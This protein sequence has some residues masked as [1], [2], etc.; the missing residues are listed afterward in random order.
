[1]I[2]RLKNRLQR[3]EPAAI[4]FLAIPAL[5]YIPVLYYSLDSVYTPFAVIDDSLEWVRLRIFDMFY[6]WLSAEFL[7]YD[8]DDLRY[9]PFWEFYTAVTWK[10]FGP[11]PWLHHLTRWATH[12]G[13]VA[14]FAAAFLCFQRRNRD[15]DVDSAPSR[16]VIRLLPLTALVYLWLFFPNQPAARLSAP[17][18][19]TVLFIALC[20]WMIALTLLRQGKPQT[21]RSTLLIYAVF[22]LSFCGIAWSKETNVA[23]ALWL[24]ISYY[25]LIAIEAMRRQRGAA[26]AS[27][28]S[29][30]K[31][32]SVW[33]A[34]GGLPLIAVFLHTLVKVYVI[35]QEGGYGTAPLTPDLLIGNAAWIAD[36]L[37]QANTSLII[38]VGF[39]LLSAALLLSTAVNIAKR[40]FSAELIFTLFLLG[41]FASLYLIVCT[42]WAQALRYWYILIPVFTTLLAFSIKR[43]MEFAAA[44]W[45]PK[46]ADGFIFARIPPLPTQNLAACALTAFI[47][48]F[49]CCNYYNFLYQT[50]LQNMLRHNEANFIS[51][52]TRLLDQDRYIQVLDRYDGHIYEPL[53]FNEF[54]AWFYGK[55]Y[56]VRTE[57]SQEAGR[58]RYIA[59]RFKIVDHLPGF[60]ESYRPLAYAYRIADILQQGSPYSVR[61]A[62]KGIIL[63]QIYDSEFNRIWWNGETLDVRQLVADA[64]SPIIRSAFEVYLNARWL[65][66]ITERCNAADI[67]DTFFLGVF[68][69]DNADLPEMRRQYGFDNLYFNF[70]DYGF[71]GGERCFA[72]RRL[73]EYPIDRIHTGQY[74]VADDGFHHTWEGDVVLSGE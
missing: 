34:L 60:E 65:I 48:F 72:I 5:L 19:Q 55:E 74:I 73:P 69:V 1:M 36:G 56:N 63:W 16:R 12:F 32:V 9:R 43:I 38:A 15:G 57:P 22:C 51:E 68:P 7:G 27:A 18:V 41:L 8:W 46:R 58:P 40:R 67:D 39:A 14:A 20:A 23:P 37:F 50:A 33:K 29:A 62:G 45:Q 54:L 71:N 4:A 26:R 10:V 44:H 13:A 28:I 6:E 24:L 59:K 42:S 66:Y 2:N 47:A 61:D 52:M 25:A 31:A 64:G 70:A 53:Y 35:S 30:L 11:V 49:V 3:F 21:R 17:E